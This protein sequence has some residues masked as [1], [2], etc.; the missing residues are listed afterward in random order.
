TE[1]TCG[2]GRADCFQ[3]W[4]SHEGAGATPYDAVPDGEGGWGV[5]GILFVAPGPH[6]LEFRLQTAYVYLDEIPFEVTAA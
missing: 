5:P 1:N 4:V 6:A 2:A 3:V